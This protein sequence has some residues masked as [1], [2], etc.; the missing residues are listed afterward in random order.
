MSIVSVPEQ[1]FLD[2]LGELPDGVTAVI[3]DP[4][5]GDAPEE[6]RDDLE[7]VLWPDIV[8]PAA[9]ARLSSL[10]SLKVLQLQSAGFE[11]MSE[12]VPDGASLANGKGVHSDET[13]EWAVTLAVSIVRGLPDYIDQQKEHVWR[14]KARRTFLAGAS[15]L[16]IGAGS[17]GSEIVA[18]LTPYKVDITS[19]G[20]TSRTAP[21]GTKVVTMDEALDLLPST[22][23]VIV[24]VPLSPTSRHLVNAD[25]LARMKDDSFLVNVARGGVLDAE[26]LIAECSSGRITAALDVTD[27]EPLPADSPL[28][29]TPNILITPHVAGEQSRY[30]EER[31]LEILRGQVAACLEGSELANIVVGPASQTIAATR[32]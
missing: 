9:N 29:D 31:V 21:D 16:V 26:A 11:H 10:P 5:T 17:I 20:R 32:S 30:S 12:A 28:W 7:I 14:V 6:I 8:D 19:V 1:S 25:F 3:W 23:V 24:I 4:Q 18:R 22:D 2:R 15:V 27:P 13:A